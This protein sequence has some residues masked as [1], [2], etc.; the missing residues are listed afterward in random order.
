MNVTLTGRRHI[1]VLIDDVVNALD[2]R[3]GKRYVDCTMGGGGHSL[4]IIEQSQPGGQLIGIDADPEAINLAQHNLYDYFENTTLIN[5]NF[6]HLEYICAATA[7]TPVD[8]ILFYL[9]LSSLQ[10]ESTERGFS[11]Q[12]SGPLDMRFNP[13]ENLTAADIINKM[14][15]EK[16]A[17]LIR[18][19][20]EEPFANRIAK[21]IVRNRPITDTALLAELVSIT[22]GARHGR[23]HPATRT[24][25]A[26]R[27]AVNR[28]LEYL[29]SALEQAI[30][31]LGKGGRL[32][33]ISYHSLEDRIVKNFLLKESKNCLCPPNI[34]E[35]R[36][37][38]NAKLSILT[39]NAILPSDNEVD[40]NTRSRSAKLRAAARL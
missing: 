24:F 34:T 9:G 15:E 5:D 26:L 16:L 7:F 36:C 1:P 12:R 20:G 35:C 29:T 3:P 38:H 23:I 21:E 18:I 32:V 25:Q 31:C 11:F 37:N 2:V 27:I 10:L 8:G 19:Y 40:T 17:Q 33:V 22:V 39:K 13:D 6:S 30:K 4:A 28:E 14:P